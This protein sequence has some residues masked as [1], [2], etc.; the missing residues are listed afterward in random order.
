MLICM[1]GVVLKYTYKDIVYMFVN[2]YMW[3]SGCRVLYI[4]YRM[5]TY[6]GGGISA[7]LPISKFAIMEERKYTNIYSR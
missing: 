4:I 7:E 6:L 2:T 5:K 1:W 3:L